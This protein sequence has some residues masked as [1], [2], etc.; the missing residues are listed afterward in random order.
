MADYK[1]IAIQRIQRLF[2]LAKEMNNNDRQ[3]K[4]KYIKRYL[5]LMQKIG[6]KTN[7]KIPKE[8]KKQ[9]CKKCYSLNIKKTKLKNTE[10]ITCENCGFEKQYSQK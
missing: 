7:T 2:D 1:T 4:T 6:T 8:I 10:K 3:D 5:T 9:Y